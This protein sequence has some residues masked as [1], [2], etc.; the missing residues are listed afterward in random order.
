[1]GVLLL[2]GR[3]LFSFIFI[4]SGINHIVKAKDMIPYA[5]MKKLPL[6][7]LLVPLSGLVVLAGA[8]SIILGL[9][10]D[11]GA[12]LIAGFCLLSS[13]I[14]HNFWAADAASKQMEMISFL[15]NVSIAGGALIIVAIVN[16]NH[17]IDVGPVVSHAHQVLFTK[18]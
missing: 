15:K 11:L 18:N 1:M 17:G 14:F 3:I 13:V 16:K 7:G 9:W 6:P 4:G 8:A 2:I 12:L 10:I 5:Q